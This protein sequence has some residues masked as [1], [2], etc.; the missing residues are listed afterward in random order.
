MVN[1]DLGSCGPAASSAQTEELD[2]ILKYLLLPLAPH[3]LDVIQVRRSCSLNFKVTFLERR[4]L[5]VALISD[6]PAWFHI[7]ADSRLLARAFIPPWSV[8]HA[9]A[10][11]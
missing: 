3:M 4:Y 5:E 10:V 9:P 2:F 6:N 7:A 1:A 8:G 11:L